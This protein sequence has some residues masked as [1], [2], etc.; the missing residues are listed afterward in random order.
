LSAALFICGLGI[1]TIGI[2][3][4]ELPA[5]RI[6]LPLSWAVAIAA[7]GRSAYRVWFDEHI[8]RVAAEEKQAARG[9]VLVFD[10]ESAI[11]HD[12]DY[13]PPGQH[14]QVF[15]VRIKNEA[16][17]SLENC[18]I[19][20]ILTAEHENSYPLC[21]PFPLLID[22][23]TYKPVI[24]HVL[25]NP[26]QLILPVFWKHTKEGWTREP[27]GLVA[28][29]FSEIVLEALSSG[30]RAVRLKLAPKLEDNHWKF[31]VVS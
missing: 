25:G 5:Q 3:G 8:A 16:G 24:E 9:L 7:G 1:G 15:L 26:M 2:L 17:I 27:G 4:V 30:T 12:T 19:Q 6:T 13:D 10:H 29:N 28:S 20:V 21:A 31:E 23:H 18:L 14:R 22:E 11:A